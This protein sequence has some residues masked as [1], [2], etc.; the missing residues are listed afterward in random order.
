MLQMLGAIVPIFSLTILGFVLSKSVYKNR[1]FWDGLDSITYY[2]FL[3]AMLFYKISNIN[4]HKAEFFINSILS[5]LLSFII[6]S[7]LCVLANF[8]FKFEARK[9]TSVY[10]G[11]A[12]FNNYIFLG[13]I[14]ALYGGESLALAALILAVMVPIINIFSVSVF[15][16]Y[17]REG[18]FSFFNTLKG[19]A[20]NPMIQACFVGF[21]VNILGVNTDIFEPFRILGSAS[22][23]C[24]LLCVGAGL[25]LAELKHLKSDFYVSS[26][27]KLIIY[28]SI[29]IWFCH[30][31]GVSGEAMAVCVIFAATPTA[32]TSYI[33]A[34]K[35]GGDKELMSLIITAQTIISAFTFTLFHAFL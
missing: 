9:F 18:K 22:I 19:I 3:P 32:I 34:T 13:I 25:R 28:P 35:L 29:A 8:I 1:L 14:E 2:V 26:V 23:V 17:I 10:Q 5:V 24:G 33:Y 21:I 7:F 11:A 16:I 15:A 4:F 6:V 31:F 12:R 20:K 27:L 30:Y